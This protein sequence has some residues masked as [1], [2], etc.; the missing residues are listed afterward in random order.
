[1]TKYGVLIVEGP[2]DIKFIRRLLE[3]MAMT[4]VQMLDDLD[5]F[6]NPKM[7][8]D[9]PP[10][11]NIEI[12]VPIPA[13]YRG[14]DHCIAVQQA[15]GD[16]QLVEQLRN[17]TKAYYLDDFVGIGVL[18]D[19]DLNE[20][21]AE[22]FAEIAGGFAKLNYEIVGGAGSVTKG[23]PNRGVFV[24]PNNHSDGALEDIM[25]DIAKST[26]PGLL[27]SAQS[28]VDSAI[29]DETL[30]S[31]DLK[32]LKRANGTIKES[33]EKKAMVATIASALRPGRAVSTS[34]HDNRWFRGENLDRGDVKAVQQFLVDLFELNANPVADG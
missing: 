25:L 16:S 6:Y 24:L 20:S 7:I 14:Q 33:G 12:R 31:D 15:G 27:A 9:Y 30:T 26:Y 22:R 13:F 23:E 1:M 34:I 2:H 17:L 5:D 10:N 11:G 18:L 28:Y 19:K 32:D 21:V 8:P 3:P 4:A 29:G